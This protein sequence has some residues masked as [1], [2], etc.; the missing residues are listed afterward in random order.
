VERSAMKLQPCEPS[1]IYA[2][3]NTFTLNSLLLHHR[4]NDDAAAGAALEQVVA[5]YQREF[6]RPDGQFTTFRAKRGP[7]W[8]MAHNW[9]DAMIAA[10]GNPAMPDV[11]RRT[12]WLLRER[13]GDVEHLKTTWMDRID[14][15]NYVH[16]SDVAMRI[17]ML[18]AAREMGDYEMDAAMRAH[19]DANFSTL[20]APGEPLYRRASVLANLQ[21]VQAMFMRENVLRDMIAFDAPA[22]WH[23]GPV[24][25]ECA[26]PA[27]LV[28]RAVT[29][30]RDLQLVLRPGAGAVRTTLRV[31]RLVPHQ[32]YRLS[33]AVESTVVADERGAALFDVDLGDR[34][35]VTVAPQ[36]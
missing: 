1:W 2:I 33:G 11:A 31:E 24:L 6:I 5:N 4:L 22:H 32:T 3:C 20:G 26:Y 12:W 29:D 21:G 10:F 15:G 9:S 13:M 36:S 35:E 23:T 7:A 27:V 34:L 8:P 16:G 25:A 30:G 17:A 18:V 14:L 19:L 28:A